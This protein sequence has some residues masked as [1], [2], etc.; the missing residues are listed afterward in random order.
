MKNERCD[1]HSKCDE[2]K[3]DNYCDKC[4]KCNKCELWKD[5]K[6]NESYS[7]STKGRIY[8]TLSHIMVSTKSKRGGYPS[9]RL[10]DKSF[11]VHQLVAKA[12]IKNPND[13]PAVNH[14]DGNKEN[15]VVSNL[16]WMTIKENNKHAI[17]NGLIT[18]T[19][20]KVKQ[21]DMDGKLIKIHD[22][23]RGAGKATGIDSG[24]IAKVC[25]GTRQSAGGF[26]W[27]FVDKNKN[28][29]KIDTSSFVQV[30]DFPN[31]LISKKGEL[32]SKPYKK[33]MKQQTNNDGYYIIQLANKGNRKTYLTHRLVAEHYNKDYKE[34][35]YVHFKD[36]NKLNIHNDNL[37]VINF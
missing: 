23:I 26:K 19:K 1:T 25:K 3:K 22:T 4:L 32:Y 34:T 29:D 5:I 27:E 12:F 15:N 9:C 14:I 16:E 36:K 20:R 6:D 37:K 35:S 30:N 21:I 17:D 31:Y 7:V 33:L 13:K 24:G 2:C 8:S 18:I 28:E 10:K 11:K